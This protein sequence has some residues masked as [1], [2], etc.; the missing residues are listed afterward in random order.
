MLL[1]RQ[2]SVGLLVGAGLV[3]SGTMVLIL[4]SILGELAPDL[5]PLSAL[6]S[7]IGWVITG[8]N[9]R[10]AVRA[11]PGVAPSAVR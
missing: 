1:L 11:R 3:L 2:A 4:G 5:S 6:P 7:G 8:W 9:L 10:I